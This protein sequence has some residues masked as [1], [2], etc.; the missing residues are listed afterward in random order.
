MVKLA[1]LLKLV[2]TELDELW[3][4]WIVFF[5][6]LKC[7]LGSVGTLSFL[8]F[9]TSALPYCAYNNVAVNLAY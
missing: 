2:P 5:E 1:C 6:N 7:N 3:E 8:D 9:S 4:V